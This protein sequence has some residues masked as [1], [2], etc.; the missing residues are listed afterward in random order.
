MVAKLE[1]PVNRARR[2]G[3]VKIKLSKK[4]LKELK[5]KSRRGLRGDAVAGA[6]RPSKDGQALK[7]PKAKKK[8]KKK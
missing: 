2:P 3:E 5:A 7:A 8:K 6:R 1:L 4:G